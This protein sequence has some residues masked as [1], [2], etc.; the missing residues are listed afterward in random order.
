MDRP[1]TDRSSLVKHPTRLALLAVLL[2]AVLAATA[3]T[4]AAKPSCGNQ[5]IDDWYGSKTGQLSKTYPLHCY[6]DALKI[7]GKETDIDVYS[8]AK[9][10]ILR[11]MQL[12]IISKG[13]GGPGNPTADPTTADA[14]PSFLGGPDAKH[15]GEAPSGTQPATVQPRKSTGN[16]LPT[17]VKA[18]SASAVPVPAIVLGGIAGL[19]L[20]LG[21][22]AYIA[23]RRQQ[24]GKKL[25][26]Q[27]ESGPPNP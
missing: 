15:G 3:G 1:I 10:D 25:R 4:A 13:K 16:N 21:G 8:N 2:L 24:H 23:R 17:V 5:V 7:V 12:A 19:L 18:S 27:T 11:A 22:T 20:I 26:P 6:K 9:E 14:L